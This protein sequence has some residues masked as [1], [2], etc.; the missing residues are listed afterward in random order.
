MLQC[1]ILRAGSYCVIPKLHALS[2]YFVQPYGE[3]CCLYLQFHIV[4]ALNNSCLLSIFNLENVCTVHVNFGITEEPPEDDTFKHRNMYEF[5]D[6][7]KY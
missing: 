5:S 7:I 4:I 2:T 6:T 1:I 3:I